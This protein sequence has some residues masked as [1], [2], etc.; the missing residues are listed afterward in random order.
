MI[1]QSMTDTIGK[2][3]VI[4]LQR[5]GPD[6]VDSHVNPQ[7]HNPAV[8][9]KDRLALAIILHAEQSGALKPGQTVVE[10]TSG[11][12]GVALAAICAA[13]GYPFVAVMTE[14]FSIERRKLIKAYGGKLVL[15]PAEIRGVAWLKKPGSWLKNTAGSWPASF[16]TRPIPPITARPRRPRSWLIL[17]AAG[18]TILSAAGARAAR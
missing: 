9:V 11:N 1:Y 14:T 3:P 17:P 16:A 18:W 13:R 5:T 10:P 7:A 4:R 6:H 8:A 2:T 12:T 15:T